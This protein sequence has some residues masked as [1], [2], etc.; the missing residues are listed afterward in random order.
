MI[1][2]TKDPGIG[3]KY[4][5]K[6]HRIINQ[7]GTFN[8]Q[9][10]GRQSRIKDI[11]LLMV[12]TSWTNFI[13]FTALYLIGINLIFAC[14]Y[15]FVG[16]HHIEGVDHTT[17]WKGFADAFFFS[18]QTFTTVGY[19]SMYPDSFGVK[20]ISSFEALLGLL[21]TALTTGLL[22]SRF[23]R[24]TARVVFSK[25]ALI[26]EYKNGKKAFMFRMVNERKE[27]LLETNATV[28]LSLQNKTSD[29]SYSRKYYNLDLQI[30]HIYFFPLTWT[31]VHEIDED[32]PFFNLSHQELKDYDAEI[33]III[34]SYDEAFYE[35][36]HI[37]HSYHIDDFVWDKKF[38]KAFYTNDHGEVI[39]KVKDVHTI[40]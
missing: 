13:F 4:D 28:I 20:A 11:Y 7:N 1:R 12:T 10:V 5:K 34:T 17:G 18:V 39:L 9:R 6:S 2:K 15:F 16:V 33:L 38:K 37:K 31:V 19:G 36:L 25:N 35:D 26:T 14:L 32:S 27:N 24:P 29:G 21:I 40:E 22:F 8:V 23:S 30:D 3:E